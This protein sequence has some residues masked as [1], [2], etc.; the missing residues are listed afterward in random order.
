[1]KDK[2]KLYSLLGFLIVLYTMMMKPKKNNLKYIWGGYI[3][4]AALLGFLESK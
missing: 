3:L 2:W 1:M 4:L